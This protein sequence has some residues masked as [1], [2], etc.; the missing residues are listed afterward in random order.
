MGTKVPDASDNLND[1]DTLAS[2]SFL[3]FLD[4]LDVVSGSN[5]Q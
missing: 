2:T 1:L 3:C 4:K 5:Q